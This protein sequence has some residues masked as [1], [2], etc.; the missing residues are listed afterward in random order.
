M[1]D[2]RYCSNWVKTRLDLIWFAIYLAIQRLAVL[3][4]W[5][6]FI[7]FVLI[8]AVA[9]GPTRRR[10]RL[11]GLTLQSRWHICCAPTSHLLH[12]AFSRLGITNFGGEDLE[13]D[14]G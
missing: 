11:A 12:S 6:P 8:G 3:F 2:R 5:W 7:G 4:S 9:E 1:P 10:I 13:A 14:S